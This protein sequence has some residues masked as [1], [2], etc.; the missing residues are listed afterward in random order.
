MS[1]FEEN[2]NNNNNNNHDSIKEK[3]EYAESNIERENY[4]FERKE[5]VLDLLGP[6]KCRNCWFLK[7]NCICDHLQPIK[8]KHRYI[9]LFHHKEW[10]RVS[11]TGKLV[12]LISNRSTLDNNNNNNNNSNNS[13]NSNNLLDINTESQSKV[14][15]MKIE[16]DEAMLKHILETTDHR[17]IFVLFPAPDSIT[18][19]EYLSQFKNNSNND[20]SNNVNNNNSNNNVDSDTISIE[21]A[22]ENVSLNDNYDF[23]ELTMIILDGTWSQAKKLVKNIPPDIKRVRLTFGE[24]KVKS[25]YNQL[26]KQPAVDRIST[27]EATALAM[28]IIGESKE[29]CKSLMDSFKYFIDKLM[30]QNGAAGRTNKAWIGDK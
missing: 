4:F 27:L 13:N 29:N 21:D 14:L 1:T 18:I 17:N 12:T 30:Q 26:R 6:T 3:A 16:E 2:N 25:L 7:I 8:F 11:N 28:H 22:L 20:K 19:E 5:K 24:Q 10:S 15:V 23:N 9:T